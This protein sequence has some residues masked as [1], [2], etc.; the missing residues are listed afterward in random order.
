MARIKNESGIEQHTVTD[1]ETVGL[2][3]LS[4]AADEQIRNNLAINQ[5]F[6][7]EIYNRERVESEIRFFMGQ[8]IEALLNVGKL[9]IQLKENEQHGDWIESLGRMSLDRRLA[10]RM[11]QAAAKFSNGALTPHLIQAAGN[12]T[13]LLELLVLDDEELTELST[14][15]S[16]AGL[17]L[18]DVA[19]MT[20][21][22]LR[23]ALRK[24]RTDS[25]ESVDI[26]DKVIS[27]KDQTINKL[28]EQV[29]KLKGDKK[30]DDF[31][32]A[33]FVPVGTDELEAIQKLTLHINALIGGEL[34]HKIDALFNAFA[35]DYPP[36]AMRLAAAQS[37]GQMITTLH[38][39]AGDYHIMPE[40]EFVNAT[41]DPAQANAELMVAFETNGGRE[42]L[43][44]EIQAANERRNHEAIDAP[45]Y[46]QVDVWEDDVD[47]F[48]FDAPLDDE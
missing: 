5:Q 29:E 48:D 24:I 34:Q 23:A 32:T 40:T 14:G 45:V 1:E 8:S 26:K 31:T 47:A 19:K 25:K 12:K 30:L 37:I 20:T 17:K 3:A 13:K 11:M 42:Q 2:P 46:Q 7:L 18:D 10:S 9:L 15:E 16:L 38:D 39:V 28:S 22:E 41:K 6:G 21:T 27:Q 4:A 43:N 35:G 33:R 36:S 44:A